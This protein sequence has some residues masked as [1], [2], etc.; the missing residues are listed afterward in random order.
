MAKLFPAIEDFSSSYGRRIVC[1][2]ENRNLVYNF[3]RVYVKIY[4]IYKRN[5]SLARFSLSRLEVDNWLISID[6][7]NIS[8]DFPRLYIIEDID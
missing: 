2:I 1:D 3:P 5:K 8:L 7:I 4:E 6:G